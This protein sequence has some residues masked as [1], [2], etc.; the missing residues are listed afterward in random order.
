MFDPA[1][2]ETLLLALEEGGPAWPDNGPVL[3]LR[4]EPSPLLSRLPDGEIICHNSYKPHHD[5]L[6]ALGYTV[7]SPDA[8]TPCR[9]RN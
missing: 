3:I 1:V 5:A 4:A 8:R 7:L 2:Y 6:S 9:R